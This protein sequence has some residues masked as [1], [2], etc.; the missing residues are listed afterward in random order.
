MKKYIMKLYNIIKYY[1]V[2]KKIKACGENLIINGKV[3]IVGDDIS[4]GNNCRINDGVS[5][6]CKYTN[7]VIIGDNVTLSNN[8]R[9]VT[10]GYVVEDFLRGQRKH[11][12][13]TTTIIGNN[14]WIGEGA[15]ILPNVKITGNNIIIGAGSVLTKDI[16]DSNCMYAGCPAK[17]VKHYT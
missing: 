17:L 16:K 3:N 11:L 10:S 1:N 12:R 9:I 7:E 2:K 6:T 14:V 8:V 4:I 15:I 5:I 13:H